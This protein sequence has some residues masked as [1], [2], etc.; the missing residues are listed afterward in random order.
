M[1]S[2]TKIKIIGSIVFIVLFI[3]LLATIQSSSRSTYEKRIDRLLEKW[4]DAVE[5]T[6]STNRFTLS[7]PVAK[8]QEIEREAESMQV[9]SNLKDCHQRMLVFMNL[10]IHSVL[11]FMRDN[12]TTSEQI[13]KEA[14]NAMAAWFDCLRYK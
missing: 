12:E 14:D 3:V 4:D 10:C 1:K 6:A 5:I 7:A 9:P 11:E 2:I 13:A 8:M